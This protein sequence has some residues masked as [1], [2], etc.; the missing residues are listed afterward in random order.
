MPRA[1]AAIDCVAPRLVIKWTASRVSPFGLCCLPFILHLH[2]EPELSRPC[3]Y[4]TAGCQVDFFDILERIAG[5]N[6]PMNANTRNIA[7]SGW[8]SISHHSPSNIFNE[9]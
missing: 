4:P 7:A 8:V 6:K 5:P 1:A 2:Y 9:F 3:T